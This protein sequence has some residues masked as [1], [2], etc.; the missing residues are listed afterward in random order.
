MMFHVKHSEDTPTFGQLSAAGVRGF[1]PDE[2]QAALLEQHV[3][4]LLEANQHV[5]L[6]AVREKSAAMRLHVLDS[7]GVIAAI[8]DAPAGRVADLGS[9]GGF[10]GIPI[11]VCTSRHIT[12]VES[13]KKKATFLEGAVESLGITGSVSVSALRAEEEALRVPGYYSVVVC[14]AL[15]ALPSLLEL[16]S[17]LLGE[18]GWMVAM[19]GRLEDAEL[20]AGRSAARLV[21]MS[22]KSISRYELPGGDEQRALVVYQKIGTPSLKLPRNTGMAQRKPLA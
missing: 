1:A 14:R 9:G 17:P 22:E 21:G 4:L 15:S 20:S 19:K 13:V 8:N 5:N 7:M 11:A 3:D 6:T 10:P 12:L 2:R 18:G 16:A